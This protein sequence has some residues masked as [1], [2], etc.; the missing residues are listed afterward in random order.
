MP[1]FPYPPI[2][3]HI[4]APEVIDPMLRMSVDQGYEVRRVRHSRPRFRYTVEWL[5][6]T[7]NEMRSIRD[8]LM[9]QRLGTL[10]FRW[11]HLT[12]RD[13]DVQVYPTTPITLVFPWGHGLFSG[14]WVYL[15]NPAGVNAAL[16][17]SVW[18]ITRLSSS[19]V[20]LNGSTSLGGPGGC[21]AQVML[22]RAVARFSEDTWQ[23][24]VKLIGPEEINHG[25][26]N[27]Q[28]IIEEVF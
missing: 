26:F 25:Y 5:G 9:Q 2:P 20:L 11:F 8:F 4:S 27:F 7:T 16:N 12:A 1:D 18:Q 23:S 6:R 3:S 13:T 22:P 28:C 21:T 10:S 17:G 14:M 24:P 15:T 19:E